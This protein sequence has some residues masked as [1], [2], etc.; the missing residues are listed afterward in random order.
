VQTNGVQFL[1]YA[2]LGSET[3]FV[4]NAKPLHQYSR[5]RRILGLYRIDPA[6]LDPKSFLAPLK[7]FLRAPVFLAAAAYSMVFLWG[8]VMTSLEIP[9]I[10][11]EKFGLNAEQVGLQNIGL[12]I[13]TLLGEQI[14]G[15]ASDKWMWQRERKGKRPEPEFRLWLSYIGHLLTICGVIVFFIQ[16]QHASD[17]WNV[18]PIVGAGIACAGN[19]IVT[20]VMITYAVDCYPEDAAA[21]GVFITLVR[22]TWGFIGPFWYVPFVILW[23]LGDC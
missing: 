6:P 5:I 12:I 21:I 23:L 17:S 15:F 1:L 10:F 13:G 11:P 22:Q 3:R 4:P 2:F 18:T 7:F 8:V 19:Q 9:Q 14:G 20:T 16:L